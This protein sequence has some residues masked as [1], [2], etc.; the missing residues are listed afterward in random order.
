MSGIITDLVIAK[1]LGV[2]VG[3]VRRDRAA[4]TKQPT[5]SAP[6]LRSALRTLTRLKATAQAPC[7]E[8][9][10]AFL[11]YHTADSIQCLGEYLI[12]VAGIMAR[13]AKRPC[14][15]CGKEI[16]SRLYGARPDAR[17]CSHRCRQRAYRK[18][19]TARTTTGDIDASPR[20]TS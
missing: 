11:G 14:A 7:E 8:A 5:K 9:A 18:R 19:V 3:T 16:T 4:R 1:M 15:S 20:D 6:T 10:K 17:Y 12:D 2:S 13:L